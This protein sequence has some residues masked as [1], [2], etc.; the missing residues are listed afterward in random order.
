MFWFQKEHEQVLYIDQ[1]ELEDTLCDGRTLKIQPDE[2][3]DFRNMP[4]NDESFSLVVFDPPHLKHIGANSWMAKK[5]GHLS[6]DTWQ[7]DLSGGFNECWR[8]LKPGG[9]LVFKWNETQIKI[10][11]VLSCFSQRPLFGHTTTHNLKTHWMIFYKPEA[12]EVRG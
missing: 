5:Y 12:E 1:R 11:E 10:K 8:V 4:Y 6:K 7:A 3:V 2:I 9:T